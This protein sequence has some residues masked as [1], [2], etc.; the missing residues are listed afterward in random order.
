MN[1]VP[2]H[3]KALLR[4]TGLWKEFVDYRD[5]LKADGMAPSASTE[6]SLAE[7]LPK[8]DKI[9]ADTK[10]D[11]GD[12]TSP[13][14]GDLPVLAIAP[15]G[16]SGK[17]AGRTDIILWVARNVDNPSPD[18]ETCPD[19]TAWTL[20]RLCR[21]NQ[22][23]LFSFMQNVWTKLIPKSVT[24]ADGPKDLEGGKPTIELIGRLLEVKHNAEQESMAS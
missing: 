24:E 22:S 12:V 7:Y 8:C 10:G 21:T 9:L 20:L 14:P 17:E 1:R 23:F 5:S 4:D 2:D 19:P 13:L 3:Q 6:A 18:V 16:L 15:D 11:P